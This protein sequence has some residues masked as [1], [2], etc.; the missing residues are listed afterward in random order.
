MRLFLILTIVLGVFI[1]INPPQTA[2]AN[3]IVVDGS[4][5]FVDAM[6]AA[7]EDTATGNC[8][9]GNGADTIVL[10]VDVDYSLSGPRTIFFAKVTIQPGSASTIKGD[11]TIKSNFLSDQGGKS[12]VF[13]GITF[14]GRL[15]IAG[16]VQNARLIFRNSYF[17]VNELESSMYTGQVIFEN[18]MIDGSDGPSGSGSYISIA[19][20]G[21]STE[22]PDPGL[23]VSNSLFTNF[24]V[25][26][27]IL[28]LSGSNINFEMKNVTISNFSSSLGDLI[29]IQ[30]GGGSSVC[31]GYIRWDHVTFFDSEPAEIASNLGT[32]W[33]VNGSIL[34]LETSGTNGQVISSSNNLSAGGSNVF[35]TETITPGVDIET[36]LADNGGFSQTL[37][38]IDHPGNPAIDGNPNCGLATDQR[39]FARDA[40]C[41]IGAYEVVLPPATDT[42]VPPTDTPVPPTDTPV[43]PTDTSIPPTDTPVPPT[44]TPVGPISLVSSAT[45]VDEN[46]AVTISAGDGPFNITASAG[47]STPVTNVGLGTTTIAGPEKWDDL[48]VTETSGD[49]ESVNLG[50]FKCRSDERPTPLTPEHQSRTTNPHPLFS[51]TPISN[52]NNYRVFVF[53]DPDAATRTVDIRQNSGG[54]TQLTLTTPL[55]PDRLF[56]RVRGRT[57]RVWSLWS[58]R[59][60]LFVDAPPALVSTPVPTVELNPVSTLPPPNS[61]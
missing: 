3:V 37:A 34:Y 7:A 29:S 8:P 17:L 42:P 32:C 24:Q 38:L 53:D 9:A 39:G 21:A 59:F 12:M 2:Q 45:C 6:I 36:T 52:A 13:D 25:N 22:V 16:D 54:P 15:D 31:G 27:G 51:W 60:T 47:I 1:Y 10:D 18:S 55:T 19:A 49:A 57:N 4:C 20:S 26:S 61:R 5:T 50:Q 23:F 43:P 48:T 30:A 44:D 14:N 28:D 33:E 56:W 35:A 11:F 58:I 41:D 40:N 46:V